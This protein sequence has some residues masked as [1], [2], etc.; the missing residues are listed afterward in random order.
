[1]AG[2]YFQEGF[3]GGLVNAK[4]ASLLRPGELVQTVNAHYRPHSDAIHKMGSRKALASASASASGAALS[5]IQY[6]QY[7]APTTDKLL[8]S[9][10]G[11]WLLGS[12]ATATA[13]AVVH[14]DAATGRGLRAVHF[15]N[16]YYIGDGASDAR[17]I[18]SAM[19]ITA[20][21]TAVGVYPMGLQ[22]PYLRPEVY[23]ISSA[24][25]DYVSAWSESTFPGTASAAGSRKLPYYWITEYIT[26]LGMESGITEVIPAIRPSSLIGGFESRNENIKIELPGAYT[27]SETHKFR[28]YRSDV[29]YTRDELE[30]IEGRLNVFAFAASALAPIGRLVATATAGQDWVDRG[31]PG[32]SEYP[33]FEISLL[34][35]SS[36]V[37]R[38]GLPPTWNTGDIYHDC[39]VV[40][41]VSKPHIIR[42]SYPGSPHAFPSIN[43]LPFRSDKA[44]KVT[45]IR[46][47]GDILLAG[48]TNSL[49]RIN[50]LPNP[51]DTFLQQGRAMEPIST[52]HGIVGPLAA[53]VFTPEGANP[54]LLF[55]AKTGIFMT[56]GF[57]LRE[58]TREFAFSQ[59]ID[60]HEGTVVKTVPN[61]WQVRVYYK[62]G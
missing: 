54:H 17:V 62:N 16:Q 42:Y 53:D 8:W 23:Y 25:A 6:L 11:Q 56:D 13:Q 5:G 18:T 34:G 15:E 24:S 47:V 22:P 50:Y 59:T 48:T 10:N 3:N 1:M 58:V 31:L 61:L 27:N 28:L 41:D 7:D 57:R 43:F 37:Q 29:F 2:G 46:R 4:D 49:W 32:T 38:N 26:G 19:A 45:F 30:A 39:L 36:F 60:P 52:E 21:S 35:V 9:Y 33:T 55:V 12:T 20:T 44:D 40:N 14:S 51:S